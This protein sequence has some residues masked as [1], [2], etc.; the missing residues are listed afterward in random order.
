MNIFV[1]MF[2]NRLVIESPGGFPPFVT[3]Q[4]I[5]DMHQPRNFWL[6]DALFY[7]KFVECAHEGTRR[8]RDYMKQ[9]GLPAPLFAQQEVGSALVQVTLKNDIEHRK[10]FIDTDAFRILGEKL[11]N[12]LSDTERRLVNFVAENRT[13]NVTQAVG[14][15]AMRWHRCKTILTALV[16]RD[17]L[18]HIHDPVIE[19]DRSQYY[20][21]KKKFSDRIRE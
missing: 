4:N 14:L 16:Q 3:P 12:S 7:L 20:V 2:D 13:I 11:S 17:I 6:M 21:L 10:E 15:T 8:I 18:D 5:Y 1:K 19:R 9:Q